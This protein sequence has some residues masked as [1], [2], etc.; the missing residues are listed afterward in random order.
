MKKNRSRWLAALGALVFAVT[1]SAWLVLSGD[2]AVAEAERSAAVTR[3]LTR[4]S[5]TSATVTFGEA[6]DLVHRVGV[7]LR[8]QASAQDARRVRIHL[9]APSGIRVLVHDGPTGGAVSAEGLDAFAGE[10]V[11]GDWKLTVEPASVKLVSWR[12]TADMGPAAY[13]GAM[14]TY[15]EYDGPDEVDCDCEVGAPA[16]TG[17]PPLLLLLAAGLLV[18]W[19]SR[20]TPR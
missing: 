15:G 5:D 11:A 1:A 10:L 12:L 8:L 13:A 6:P 18:A 2:R 4:T 3:S 19:R 20:S 16:P 9:T 17:G 14:E 7:H